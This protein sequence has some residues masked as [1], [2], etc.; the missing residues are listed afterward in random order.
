MSISVADLVTAILSAPATAPFPD[1]DT[2]I[3][4][5]ARLA[6]TTAQ[7]QKQIRALVVYLNRLFDSG[8]TTDAANFLSYAVR[9]QP[10]IFY[11][12]KCIVMISGAF[13]DFIRNTWRG[14]P[15]D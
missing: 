4:R 13:G 8:R 3:E 9:T 14:L 10:S 6:A 5:V 2:A 7:T 11:T 1:S 12:H 15:P